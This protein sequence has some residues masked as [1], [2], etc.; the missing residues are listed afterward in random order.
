M[1]SM[2][3]VSKSFGSFTALHPLDMEIPEG[4]IFGLL[5]PNGAGKT[6]LLRMIMGRIFPNGGTIRLFGQDAPGSLQATRQIGYMPQEL[7]VYEGLT[8]RENILFF[9]GLYGL[10]EPELSRKADELLA[11]VE[12][13]SKAEALAGNLSGGQ[14]RRAMLASALIHRPRLLILD[15]PTAGVDP[16][17][18]LKFW[19]WF[20]ELAAEGT[21]ILITTHHIS[22]AARSREVVFMRQG[23][24]LER[25]AP[26]E[27]I[28]RYKAHDL[29]DAF[30]KATVDHAGT[31]DRINTTPAG[32][33]PGPEVRS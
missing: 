28:A 5:G 33:R 1:I 2:V 7:A 4:A 8:V 9:G 25:G 16:L 31:L 18:R 26:A 29:E 32:S 11:R 23:Y 24:L 17:L 12:L 6:T 30:V 21:S 27:I 10:R 19:D 20:S 13:E 22:E 3:Q 15:E 14:T